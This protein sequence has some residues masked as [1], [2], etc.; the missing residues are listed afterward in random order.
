MPPT[1][2]P[3]CRDIKDVNAGYLHCWWIYETLKYPPTCRLLGT[4]IAHLQLV[5][6]CIFQ[7]KSVFVWVSF[8]FYPT[9]G[10][11]P[12]WG[13]PAV[14]CGEVV[15]FHH[16]LVWG[17]RHHEEQLRGAVQGA[18]VS[19]LHLPTRGLYPHLYFF[20]SISMSITNQS[21]PFVCSLVRGKRPAVSVC[22]V[23]SDRYIHQAEFPVFGQT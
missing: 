16:L 15:G 13:P 7:T 23:C 8:S 19:H 9:E 20:W 22:F 21:A 17:V 4:C 11:L 5:F 6:Q 2:T 12:S 10:F 18:G 3:H 1:R 14:R